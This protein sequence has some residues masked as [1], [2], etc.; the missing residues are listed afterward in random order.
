LAHSRDDRVAEDREIEVPTV[1]ARQGDRRRLNLRVLT[2]SLAGA[3]VLLA[4]IY[5]AFLAR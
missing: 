4:L 1:E 2:M 3:I 5:F